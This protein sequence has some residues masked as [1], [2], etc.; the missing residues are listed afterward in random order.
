[1]TISQ[2]SSSQASALGR[3]G[4][5][6]QRLARALVCWRQRRRA[7]AELARLAQLGDYLLT[8]VGL[9]PQLA[10]DDPARLVDQVIDRD[11]P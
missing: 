5:W 2:S 6:V 11:R 4:G 7:Q 10:R 3:R 8:D 1:M 9:D